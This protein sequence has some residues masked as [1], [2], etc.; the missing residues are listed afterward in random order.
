M[1]Q[2]LKFFEQL[3]P[4]DV[5][6]LL[7]TARARTILSQ[8]ILI[9][10]G[11]PND[12]LYFITD[13]LFNVLAKDQNGKGH[14]IAQLGP[15]EIVGELSWLQGKPISATIQAAESSSVLVLAT[16]DLE[17]KIHDAK[18][19]A[20]F[21]RALATVVAERMRIAEA[22]SGRFEKTVLDSVQA[23]NDD[24]PNRLLLS[25]SH[26]KEHLLAAD[27]LALELKGRIP[28]ERSDVIQKEFHELLVNFN[29][30]MEVEPTVPM[31]T[32]AAF[33]ALMQREM[34]P[35]ISLAA[36][37]ERFYSKP[38]GYA[39]DYKAIEMMY[40]N[41]PSGVGRIGPLL[42]SCFLAEPACQAA[43]NRRI[44]L[45]T[46]ILR[47]CRNTPGVARVTSL[48]CGP[49]RELFDAIENVD[50]ASFVFTAIDIDQEA[51]A[52]LDSRRKD[53][54][55]LN[56]RIEHGNLIYLVMGRE[57]LALP[58]QQLVYS[59]GLIDYFNDEFVIRLMNWIFDRLEVGGRVILGNFHPRNPDKAF[60]DHVL[61]WPLIHRNESKM[62]E[63]YLKSKFGR[64]CTRIL[65]EE[66]G[67]NLF[68]ECV[69]T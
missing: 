63:L 55:K 24:L 15:G 51:L 54:P 67:I 10:E 22:R 27:K 1:N 14:K 39:G 18:F 43:R 29:S 11:A 30:L 40:D 58:P 47:S 7:Q 26:F 21:F 42:D 37:A 53:H 6:W 35:Y 34:L 46:E 65:F 9:V 57:K 49:A 3:A 45:K 69:K 38:R 44:L 60:M 23:E 8:D 12:G 50:L 66:Q 28:K 64:T 41:V 17:Q 19:A 20:N 2:S 48:A 59:I 5:D 32:K 16:A 36:S 52:L 33:A 31:S 25:V 56:M 68:A 62:D 13:G 4:A 61:D